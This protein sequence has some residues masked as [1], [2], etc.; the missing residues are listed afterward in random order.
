MALNI[1]WTKFA[2]KQLHEIFYYYLYKANLTVAN[3]I[4]S[5][6]LND[7][8]IILVHPEVGPIEEILKTR[9]ENFRFLIIK[10]YKILYWL[11]NSK[12]RIEI[13]DVFDTR[14]NPKKLYRNIDP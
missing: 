4:V 1:Y 8:P 13:V 2:T 7:I 3:G 5:K 6:I 14:Q 12:N 10:N 11:N 9:K